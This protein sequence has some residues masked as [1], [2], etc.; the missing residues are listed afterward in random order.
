MAREFLST[1][2]PAQT[3]ASA[4]QHHRAGNLSEAERLYRTILAQNPHHP[5]AL[6]LLGVLALQ[7][8]RPAIAVPL[9]CKAIA[10]QPGV[11]SYYNNLGTAEA[12]LRNYPAAIAALQEALR[13]KP[14]YPEAWNA[15]G[16]AFY[17]LNDARA[18]DCFRKA[19]HLQVNCAD[20]MINLGK[21]LAFSGRTEESLFL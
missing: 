2:D 16:T 7:A 4:L 5:D 8:D 20:A 9:I 19:L 12:Q 15:L 1:F 18:E 11:A 6:H 10:I 13:L 3:F 17:E 14:G 21:M